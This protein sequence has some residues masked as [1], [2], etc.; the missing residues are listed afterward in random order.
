MFYKNNSRI[1]LILIFF[2]VFS[3]AQSSGDVRLAV[4]DFSVQ[5]GNP[6]YHYLGKGFAE[7]L[8]IELDA[9]RGI[10]I[11]D[12]S[13]RNE[14]M[15]EQAFM[16][17]GAADSNT[18][19]EAGQL[20]AANFLVSGDIFEMFGD[21]VITAKVTDIGS[22]EVIASAK[23][24]GEPSKYKVMISTLVREI[25]SA[26]RPKGTVPVAAVPPEREKILTDEEANKVLSG[27]SE[28]V[29]AVDKNDVDTAKEKL[30]QVKKIDKENKA[31]QFYLNKLL[32]ISPKF[33]IEL[34]YYA[35]SLNPGLLG[36]LEGDRLYLT[37]ST[38]FISPYKAVYPDPNVGYTNFMWE[39]QA[40]TF[41]GY[42]QSKIEI[43]YAFP[44]SESMGMNVEFNFGAN[45]SVVRDRNYDIDAWTVP[46]DHAYIR[47]GLKAIGGR[48][49]F[50]AALSENFGLGISGYIFDAN[51]NLG[52]SDGEGD[53]K[54]DT[55]SAAASIGIY[56]KPRNSGWFFESVISVPFLQEVYINYDIKDYVAYETAPFPIVWD[57]TFIFGLIQNRLYLSVKELMETYLSYDEDDDRFG[58]ASRSIL[59]GEFW[60]NQYFSL[61]LGGEFDFLYLMEKSKPGGGIMGGFSLKLGNY[62]LDANVT[63]M[64][65]ALR[66]YPGYA[67]PDLTLLMQLSAESLFFKGGR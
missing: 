67:V 11:I 32:N 19:I 6:D 58:I 41:Y 9:L 47:S 17:S 25:Y 62:T 36:F 33:N 61:R 55:M 21:L 4:L 27:F 26:I 60:F 15:K 13:K 16:L 35:P 65:R 34:I 63:W 50:G 28:A 10:R 42:D 2:P 18:L 5:S 23:A 12:R 66:F 56:A 37:G 49:G 64:E 30:E 57:T 43:G 1:I 29:D 40:G 54:S 44:L 8:S 20:L 52:G 22:G 3:N 51:M 38:N 14:I 53:P 59:A 48:L 7:F 46:E 31:V 39:F 24:E 45:D